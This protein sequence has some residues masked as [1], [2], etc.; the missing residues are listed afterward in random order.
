MGDFGSAEG[1]G[2]I[3]VHEVS[4]LLGGSR[5]HEAPIGQ[6]AILGPHS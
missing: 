2:L 5:Q 3:A 4:H 6:D 1:G